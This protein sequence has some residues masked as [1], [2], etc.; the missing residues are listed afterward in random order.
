MAELEIKPSHLGLRGFIPYYLAIQLLK[1]FTLTRMLMLFLLAPLQF[2]MVVE[3]GCGVP[4]LLL[5][6]RSPWGGTR[7]GPLRTPFHIKA[8]AWGA[9]LAQGGLGSQACS[10]WW[11]KCPFRADG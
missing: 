8:P 6:L 1:Q 10:S 9:G 11:I 7:F 3:S 5:D 2:H 4:Q